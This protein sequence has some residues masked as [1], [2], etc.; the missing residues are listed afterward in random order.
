MPLPRMTTRRWMIAVAL[1]AVILGTTIWGGRLLDDQRIAFVL[2]LM[3][4]LSF[5]Y[6]WAAARYARAAVLAWR[7]SDDSPLPNH[8]SSR[9]CPSVATDPPEPK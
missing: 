6:A 7:R 2:V 3:M 8:S 5:V 9:P 4:V 1:V